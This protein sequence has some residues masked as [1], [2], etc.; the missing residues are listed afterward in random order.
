M[1][2]KNTFSVTYGPKIEVEYLTDTAD[3]A[4]L[5]PDQ[6]TELERDL[7]LFKQY[8]R[9]SAG[10][11]VRMELLKSKFLETLGEDVRFIHYTNRNGKKW[12]V[13][14]YSNYYLDPDLVRAKLKDYPDLIKQYLRLGT[15]ARITLPASLRNRTEVMRL[16]CEWVESK[17]GVAT[18]YEFSQLETYVRE[19]ELIRECRQR[20]VSLSG[21]QKRL[22]R[23]VV[24]EEKQ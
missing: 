2:R 3:T 12:K 22:V 18:N 24:S 7:R 20:R 4:V 23:A 10:F 1:A 6:I 19:K 17:Y 5:S 9:T 8:V 21:T 11:N 16:I 15:S 13:A 14:L